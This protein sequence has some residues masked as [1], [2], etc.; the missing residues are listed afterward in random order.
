MV[1]VKML[2][3]GDEVPLEVH[4]DRVG[5]RLVEDVDEEKGGERE[6][7]QADEDD[8][9]GLADH[10]DGGGGGKDLGQLEARVCEAVGGANVDR[11]WI[12]IELRRAVSRKQWPQRGSLR[13]SWSCA[14]KDSALAAA[15]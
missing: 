1:L 8:E 7:L 2:D 9:S 12:A 5:E 6:V 10:G 3:G 13:R 15:R 11:E 4:R 14:T